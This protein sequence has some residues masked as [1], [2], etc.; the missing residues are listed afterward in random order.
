MNIKK[1]I[2]TN[3]EI[4]T[5]QP[6]ISVETFGFFSTPYF[7]GIDFSENMAFFEFDNTISGLAPNT[8]VNI[9]LEIQNPNVFFNYETTSP[10]VVLLNSITISPGTKSNTII[11]FGGKT[12]IL[13]GQI[14]E[15]FKFLISLPPQPLT[16]ISVLDAALNQYNL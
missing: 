8:I 7:K 12:D 13:K 2:I 4:I 1:N 9:Y 15:N 5:N 14:F 16:T 3:G 11:A 6:D 10:F